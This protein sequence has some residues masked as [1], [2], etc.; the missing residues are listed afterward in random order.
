MGSDAATRSP[1]ASRDEEAAQAARDERVTGNRIDA[2]GRRESG[3]SFGARSPK[4][5]NRL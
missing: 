2:G 1:A 3:W 4:L 5:L